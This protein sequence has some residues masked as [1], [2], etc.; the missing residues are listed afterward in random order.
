MLAALVAAGLLSPAFAA[1]ITWTNGG[2]D[3]LWSTATNWTGGSGVPTSSDDVI[4]DNTNV[5]GSYTVVL[6]G[7]TVGATKTL[8]IGYAGN[9]NTI[10]L[11]VSSTA[12]PAVT[13]AGDGTSID[14]FVIDAGGRWENTKASGNS[15]T[16]MVSPNLTARVKSGGYL[17]HNSAGSFGTPF[18][19]TATTFDSGSTVEFGHS[20]GNSAPL[21]GR[22]Y[23]NL[24]LSATSAKT[25]TGNGSGALLVQNDLTIGPNVTFNPSMT[26]T[27]TFN[28]NIISN[29]GGGALSTT[30]AGGVSFGGTSTLSGSGTALTFP[31]GVTI[32]SSKSLTLGSGTAAELVIPTGKTLSIFGT[33]N[34]NG[35]A[36]SGAG[37]VSLSSIGTLGIAHANG[38]NGQITTSGS[39]SFSTSASYVYNGTGGAQ[40][41][42]TNLPATVATL[43]IANAAGVTLSADVSAGT[44]NLTNG[45]L[46]TGAFKVTSTSAVNR[47]SGFV[48]GTLARTIDNAVGGARVYPIGSTG[49]Y[50]PVTATL[51]GGGSGTAT[52]AASTT[53]GP[54]SPPTGGGQVAAT[55]T[56]NVVVSGGTVSNLELSFQYIESELNG[57]VEADLKALIFDG[58]GWS[59]ASSST[60]D[61]IINTV[62]RPNLITFTAGTTIWGVGNSGPSSV[63]DWP[64]Q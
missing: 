42:G 54:L 13:F 23:G 53:A 2:G 32:N 64:K 11:Q 57:A 8:K 25:Y 31:G 24:I 22:T 62:T 19:A 16:T 17:L 51:T 59:R 21:S 26:G 12:T 44:L 48:V 14:D 29:G 49:A 45:E 1:T 47:T 27:V 43:T 30:L 61:T 38:L 50:A 9:V 60:V 28:G 55:R 5:P 33:L 18:A 36:V 58:V 37:A 35:N 34:C 6:N 10:T 46:T 3:G 63:S 52:L 56:W 39:N 40:V 4:L 7:A 15:I 20:S 41:T